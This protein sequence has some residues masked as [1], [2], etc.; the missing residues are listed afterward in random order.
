[1]KSTHKFGMNNETKEKIKKRYDQILTRGERFWP[2]SI[3]K[4]AVMALAIFLVLVLLASFVG[5]P[6]EPKADPSDTSYIP[7]PEWYFLF[8]FQT[9]KFLPTSVLGISNATLVVCGSVLIGLA[10]VIVPAIDG[11]RPNGR[12]RRARG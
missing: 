12:L 1:M 4:D 8:L 7:R 2:D 11:A 10:F 9:I 3:F 5:V 6:V